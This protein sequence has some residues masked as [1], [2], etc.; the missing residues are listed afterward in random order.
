M[1]VQELI[2]GQAVSVE[3]TATLRDA[4]KQM[5]GSEV[6]ALV[7]QKDSQIVG[8]ITERDILGACA[9]DVD[10]AAVP[11]ADWMTRDPDSLGPE[12]TVAASADW[13]LAAGYRHLPVVEGTEIMGMVSIKDIL[14]GLTEPTS[15]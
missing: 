6:G 1:I 8:I 3:P 7:V 15:V 11:V 2:G 5:T 10:L 14:W 12:M 13:M 4:V 9:E